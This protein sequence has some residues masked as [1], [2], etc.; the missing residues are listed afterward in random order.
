MDVLR[1]VAA[2]NGDVVI[3]EPLRA[4]DVKTRELIRVVRAFGISKRPA[5]RSNQYR[6]A[7]LNLET[8][9]LDPCIQIFR[10]D[11]RARLEVLDTLQSG[12]I[13][14]HAAGD[15]AVLPGKD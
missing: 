8:R 4:R 14:E 2:E 3:S 1:T 7:G 5:A 10:I 6:I 15:D 12:N 9:L 11:P 13:H